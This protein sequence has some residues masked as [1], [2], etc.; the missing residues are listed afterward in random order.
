MS[1][2]PTLL[3]VGSAN[4][5]EPGISL[6][7]SQGLDRGVVRLESVSSRVEGGHP[8]AEAHAAGEVQR[9]VEPAVAAGDDRT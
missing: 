8:V 2:R 6:S 5:I 3:A 7:T 9:E 1:S 4:Q